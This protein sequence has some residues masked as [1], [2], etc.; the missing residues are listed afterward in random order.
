MRLRNIFLIA[1][2]GICAVSTAAAQDTATIKAWLGQSA[3]LQRTN[4]AE[5]QR[6]AVKALQAS[7]K[8]GF[9]KGIASACIRIGSVLY[10]NGKLDSAKLLFD[11]SKV[12]YLKANNRTG[13]AGAALLLSYLYQDKGLKDSAFS[14]LFQALRWNENSKDSL[15]TAQI[16]IHLGNLYMDY[17]D[18]KP[19]LEYFRSALSLSEKISDQE[20]LISACDGLGRYYLEMKQP[21]TALDY[22]HRVDHICRA[23]G[24]NYTIA[25]N[26]NNIALCYEQQ[27]NYTEANKHYQE[28]LKLYTSLKMTSEMATTNYNI[29]NAFLMKLQPDSA[30]YHLSTAVKL[31]RETGEMVRVAKSYQLLSSAYAAKNDYAKAYQY[32][33][34]YS[35]LND[36][37]INQDK[38]TAIADMQTR[39]DTEKK[40]QQIEL[41]SAQNKIKSTQRNL[42]VI[43]SIMLLL[44]VV[45]VL[46]GWKRT[47]REKKVSESLLLNIL[48]AEVADELKS[49]GSSDAR[50][51]DEVTVLF[52]DF[53]DF[54]QITE[55]MTPA[56][57]VSLLHTC[58][59]AFDEIITRHR[60]EK[61]KTIGDS[62]MCAGG[63]PVP[64]KSNAEDVV[65][66][67][68]DILEFMRK[69]KL[70]RESQGKMGLEMRIGIHTGPV[71][72]G[73][74]GIK[75][76]AYDI[77]GDTVNTASRMESSGEPGK[78]NISETT[79][80]LVKD[81]FQFTYRGKIP[82]K[83]KGDLEMYFVES[84]V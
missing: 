70:E 20:G 83:H 58:F 73:I 61:M 48:P 25:Q 84:K 50:F 33:Q 77:W 47:S 51:F 2:I 55:T 22:F 21:E 17:H 63:L 15:K 36:S 79:Y 78:I 11:K 68:L 13:A 19:A 81:R 71:V 60:V 18:L 31:A 75:K 8:I 10:T 12:I 26:E 74:V 59:K 9:Q 35:A 29:G 80:A 52:T 72:A 27:K 4:L 40:V 42:F 64:N 1:I 54:T 16:L 69:L 14:N 65:N 56:E 34:Y 30:I 28:A 53:K 43:A 5:S 45:A 44:L 23:N 32:H 76:F 37:I 41:L 3:D 62:Y 57:L 39:Y 49:K 66:A 67:A 24:D 82:A 46:Y 7:E 6:L 38:V